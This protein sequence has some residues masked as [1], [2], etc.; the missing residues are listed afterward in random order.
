MKNKIMKMFGNAGLVDEENR[1]II[2]YGLTRF[3]AISASWFFAILCAAIMGNVL[4]GFLFEAC[5]MLLRSYVGGYHAGS[6]K[7]CFYL[8]YI[9]TLIFIALIFLVHVSK[10][11]MCGG[12]LL[13]DLAIVIC[14]PVQSRNKPLNSVEKKV[15]QKKSIL[16]AAVET[17]IFFVC[18]ALDFRIYAGTLFFGMLLVV[19][20]MFAGLVSESGADKKGG[21][22]C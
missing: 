22:E 2:E 14:A 3:F 8:T 7:S 20:G 9:S 17:G 11:V 6:K 21:T 13:F 4:V 5:Y 16:I 15:Y 19:T 18:A 1:E 12:I 10:I